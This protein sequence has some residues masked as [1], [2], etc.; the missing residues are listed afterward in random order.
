MS[1]Q[2]EFY[3]SGR[4]K[5][6]GR[7][8]RSDSGVCRVWAASKDLPAP[9]ARR[10]PAARPR[11][12]RAFGRASVCFSK[13]RAPEGRACDNRYPRN[14]A[15]TIISGLPVGCDVSICAPQTTAFQGLFGLYA[16][17]SLLTAAGMGLLSPYFLLRS[18]LDGKSVG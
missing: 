7:R 10:R 4:R 5:R 8:Q 1:C 6:K 16:L 9:F 15:A 13:I 11:S 17:Y 14:P 2:I 12:T 18:L 3:C